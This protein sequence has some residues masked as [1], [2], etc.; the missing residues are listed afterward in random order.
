MALRQSTFDLADPRNLREHVLANSSDD[1]FRPHGQCSPTPHPP[2]SW[3][4][5]EVL[6]TRVSESQELWHPEDAPLVEPPTE[7]E[8]LIGM[9]RKTVVTND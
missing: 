8:L 3:E 4:K 9:K 5:V 7:Y 2:G 6:A 1:G